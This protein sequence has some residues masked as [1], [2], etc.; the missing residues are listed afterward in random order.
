MSEN[1]TVGKTVTK[2]SNRIRIQYIYQPLGNYRDLFLVVFF[3]DKNKLKNLH[4]KLDNLHKIYYTYIVV[5]RNVIQS[6]VKA[7]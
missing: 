1:P 4:K 6:F 5:G 2:K 7:K 3:F